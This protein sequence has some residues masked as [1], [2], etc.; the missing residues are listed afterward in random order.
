MLI[1]IIV[2]SVVYLHISG[3][4]YIF[5]G[6]YH[7]NAGGF[8]LNLELVVTSAVG[9]QMG[10]DKSGIRVV[11]VKEENITHRYYPVAD[12]PNVIEL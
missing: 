1:I 10:G 6:H 12:V 7:R 11:S 4:R 3:V 9:A 5:S 2:S 8:Y